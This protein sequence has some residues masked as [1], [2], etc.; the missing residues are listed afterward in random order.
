M[1]QAHIHAT[2]M[3]QYAQDAAETETPWERWEWRA[4]SNMPF[5]ACANNPAWAPEH[6][7]R[8]KP[9]TITVNGFEVPAPVKEAA[10]HQLL[11][12]ADPAHS[13]WAFSMAY[14]L[15]HSEHVRQ[16][17]RG[18]LHTTKEAAVAHAKAMLGIDP[19][20]ETA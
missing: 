9:Q 15:A 13:A 5:E 10:E 7:Y 11:W 6:A 17:R 14:R 19:K 1:T 20:G 18:L 2:L 4:G 3:L 16:F 12:A 8:R